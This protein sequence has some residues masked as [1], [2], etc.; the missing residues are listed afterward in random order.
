MKLHRIEGQEATTM[1]MVEED[2]TENEEQKA[3]ESQ[4]GGKKRKMQT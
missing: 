1:A 2:R 4:N 3:N